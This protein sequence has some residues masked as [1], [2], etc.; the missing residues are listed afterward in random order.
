MFGSAVPAG[1]LTLSPPPPPPGCQEIRISGAWIQFAKLTVAAGEMTPFPYIKG[2]TGCIAMIVEIVELVGK[3]N[4]DLQDLAESIGMTIRIIRETVEAHG[5]TSVTR[6]H[7]VCVELQKYLESLIA[8]L[9]ITRCKLKSKKRFLTTKK[10]SG[11]IDGYKQ[12]VNDIKADY[13]VL[14]TTNSRLAMSE[15]QDALSATIT[16]AMETAICSL[17]EIQRAHAAQMCEK[18]QDLKGYY[19]RQVRELFPGDIYIGKLVSPSRHDS[20]LEYQDRY[21]TVECSSTA[22]IIR[23]YQ[24][25]TDTN[26]EAILKQFN[27]VANALINI[28]HPNIAQIFGICRSPN[29]P[30]IIFH[31]STQIPFNDY[32]CNLTAKQIIPFYIQLYY[33][34][35][36]LSEYLSR[37]VPH[38]SHSMADE[39][40]VY[41][42]EHGQIVMTVAATYV[43]GVFI[44]HIHEAPIR[45]W[46]DWQSPIEES[47][48]SQINRW[49]SS[50]TLQKD[51]L[52]NAYDAIKCITEI[53]AP[54]TLGP[55]DTPYAPGSVLT[56]H[57]G[58]L[59]GKVPIMLD[60]WVVKWIGENGGTTTTLFSSTSNGIIMVPLPYASTQFYS[61][62]ICLHSFD[63][64]LDSWIA[65]ASQLQSCICSRGHIDNDRLSL[66]VYT[67][68][69]LHVSPERDCDPFHLCNTFMAE[70][71][72]M[73]SVSITT[74]SIDYLT[75]KVSQPVFTWYD[76][77]SEIS[78][79]EVEQVF[80]VKLD[81]SEYLGILPMSKILLTT[82][83]E[84]NADYGF[85]PACGGTD[86]CKYFG[87]P[88][89]EILNDSTGDWI[90]LHGTVSESASV[91]SDGRYQTLSEVTISPLENAPEGEHAGKAST[92][93]GIATA[94]QTIDQKLKHGSQAFIIMFIVISAI[95][96]SFVVQTYM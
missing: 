32:E 25:P 62:D 6:F 58:T 40:D 84:L 31:G 55:Q 12:R 13:L 23:V 34:L 68:F 1:K 71:H 15:M 30:A 26:E 18:F 61:A 91:M 10:V 24:H 70:D 50:L 88:L 7:D 77:D 28:K 73:L 83:S 65:Q 93:T 16:Q 59:V 57:G 53:P 48:P 37:H 64:M 79:V 17:S 38:N 90:P 39:H 95:L 33:D 45:Y 19:K 72:H 81:V 87:W 76:T 56:S 44:T 21:C 67:E 5:D 36:S 85:D 92:T 14:V 47:L 22:K 27:E 49:S 78:P 74:P 11:V 75:N 46:F 96:L 69:C 54:Q 43:I 42:N 80:G 52:C 3:N 29:F 63:G 8:E 51:S 86:I 4:E 60:E 9:N 35:K 41:L 20:A 66:I 2:V 94:A 82:I 89:M